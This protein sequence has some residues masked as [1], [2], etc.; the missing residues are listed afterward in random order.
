MII[1]IKKTSTEA[2]LKTLLN[3][4]NS[5]PPTDI[6]HFHSFKHQKCLPYQIVG[7]KTANNVQIDPQTMDIWLLRL[8]VS[9]WESESVTSIYS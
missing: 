5:K 6:G 2:Q 1:N 3:Y 9:G 7:N 4:I 8:N